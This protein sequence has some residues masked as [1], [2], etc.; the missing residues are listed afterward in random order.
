[1]YWLLPLYLRSQCQISRIRAENTEVLVD[2]YQQ[3]QADQLRFLIAYRHLSTNDP[4][5][6]IQ[7]LHQTVPQVAKGMGIKL[8]WPVF[9][10]FVYDRG[11][12]MWAGAIASWLLP[13]IGGIPVIR[14]R[15]DFAA[16]RTWRH[17]YAKG[18]LPI[19]V[20][21]EGFT[22][23]H[24]ELVSP[25]ELGCIQTSLWCVEDLVKSGQPRPV[26]IVP[27]GVRYAYLENPWPNLLKVLRAMERECGFPPPAGTVLQL[28]NQLSQANANWDPTRLLT[29]EEQAL[30]YPRLLRIANFLLC[31]MEDF[32]LEFH[33]RLHF[34]EAILPGMT[35]AEQLANRLQAL[36]DAV[37]KML[38]GYF[39][40]QPK[41]TLIER[42][43]AIEDTVWDWIYRRDVNIQTL[44]DVERGLA[45]R[46][47]A[48]AH[49]Q[50]WH[51]KWVE[52]FVTVT[53]DYL[54]QKP[55]TRRFS[56]TLLMLHTLIHELAGKDAARP[57]IA[58]QETI[59]TIGNPIPV[60][61]WWE[62]YQADHHRHKAVVRELNQTLK[63]VLES[64]LPDR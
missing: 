31:Q 27:V 21:P 55:T 8:R 60:N 37:L 13:A 56:E 24:S 26:C 59:L 4:P 9:A 58:P 39:N 23:G 17:L 63:Q 50:L 25:L 20:A 3:L 16:L 19:A 6:L 42:S 36:M 35:Q 12:P 32:Y 33:H 10:Y 43:H 40:M 7:Y 14:G 52:N 47:A 1:M 57:A 44:S 15:P 34:P 38:E 54:Q 18:D 11:I 41:G 22:N 53:G 29:P 28:E 30:L 64:M 61:E 48:E 51:M 2:C 45:N 46:V 62:A 5:S 49:A